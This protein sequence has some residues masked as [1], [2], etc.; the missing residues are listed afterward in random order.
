MAPA[1]FSICPSPG[2]WW[3]WSIGRIV[4]VA[5]DV[6]GKPGPPFPLAS[7]APVRYGARIGAMVVYLSHYQLLPEDRLAELMADMFAVAL[8]P[9]TVARMGRSRARRFEGVVEVIR[10]LVKSAPVKHMDETGLRVGGRTQWLHVAS[11][12]GLTFYRVSAGRGSLLD[13]VAGIVVHDHWKPY[14]TMQGVDHALC[15]AH[16]LRELQALI[17]IEKEGWARKMRRLLRRA[18]HAAKPRP[19]AGRGAATEPRRRLPTMVGRHHG[20]G[21]PLSRGPAPLGPAP[22]EGQAKRRGRKPRRTGHNLLLRLQARKEDAL[23]F[24]ANLAVPFTNNQAEQDVR[25]A[26]L[27]QKISGGFRSE[28]G[29]ERLRDH[30]RLHLDRQKTG[31]EHHSRAHGK[32]RNPDRSSPRRL[33]GPDLPGQLQYILEL[34]LLV[35]FEQLGSGLITATR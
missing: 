34:Y 6:A 15:N 17:E 22:A 16:H 11:S 19:G 14:F 23:R 2:P 1:R 3:S 10:D 21:H 7:P 25:M 20:R 5:G 26:K 28:Q 9:A 12:A 31:L 4:A 27:K 32:S 8:V 18:C 13:G 33:I 30:P 24:L 35:N 29:G